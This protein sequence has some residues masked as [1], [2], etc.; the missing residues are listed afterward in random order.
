MSVYIH[1]YVYKKNLDDIIYV[2]VYTCYPAGRVRDR[3][4]ACICHGKRLKSNLN[5][6]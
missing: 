3:T 2:H 5:E 6:I 1:V 4:H